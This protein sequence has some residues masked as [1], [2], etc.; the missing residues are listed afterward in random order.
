MSESVSRLVTQPSLQ[1][2]TVIV[3]GLG[4]SGCSAARLL[5]RLG[6]NVIATDTRPRSALSAEAQRLKAQLLVGGHDGVDF[7]AA[8]FI[9][10]SPGVPS[11]PALEAAA[12]QGVEVI[13][14]TE[15]ACRY[16]DVPICAIG[17][18]NGKSSVTTLVG[19]LLEAAGHHIFLGGNLGEPACE[20]PGQGTDFVV[21][22]VSSFQMERLKHFR[23]AAAV[24]LNI[25]ED[26]L[27]RYP[28]FA[29]Y[30]QAKGNCFENQG[31][32]DV[33]VYP[34]GDALCEEQVR[35]GHGRLITF[36]AHGDYFVEG[37]SVVERKTK[38]RFELKDCDLH[39]RHNHE[40]A[41]AAIAL[42]RALGLSADDILEGLRR[43][44]ALPHRMALVGRHRDVNFYDDSKATNVGA[45]VTALRGLSEEKG[46]LIA[47][48]RDKMGSYDDLVAAV[49]EKARGVVVLG[50]AADRIRQALGSD[51][52]IEVAR[53]IQGAVV[54]AFKLARPG[55]AV[56]LSPAC[57]SLDM[58][59]NYSERGERFTEAVG[60]LPKLLKETHL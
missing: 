39:G 2:K 38:T 4:T 59:K 49:R 33:A 7:A 25:T 32:K 37:L 14:E 26:H 34:Q 48:G 51:V 52:P 18:T 3:V 1:G 30:A 8:E 27:D 20:A 23:P 10:V 35:R 50:E 11:F 16:I 58:F 5:E 24:L 28:T 45:A 21:L 60:N 43:F 19:H 47:G 55:D 12:A 17:G 44:R 56:L 13:G 42:G 29:E 46:V 9:V 53:T 31:P 15:L 40:N 22:E 41:A 54:R 6:A 36:G 57:S